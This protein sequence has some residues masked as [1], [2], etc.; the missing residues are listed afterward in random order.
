[1]EPYGESRPLSMRVELRH[2]RAWL[3]VDR[4]GRCISTLI[5]SWEDFSEVVT[6]S[7]HVHACVEAAGRTASRSAV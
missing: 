7:G 4:A 1:M 5:P 3:R 2:Y 6:L